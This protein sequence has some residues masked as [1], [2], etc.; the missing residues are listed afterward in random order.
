VLQPRTLSK[1]HF[2]PVPKVREDGH[3]E[4]LDRGC[5]RNRNEGN[6]EA[7]RCKAGSGSGSTYPAIT[8]FPIGCPTHDKTANNV[9]GSGREK[10]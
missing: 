5:R 1:R 8:T 9:G 2:V 4:E 3:E 10:C 6:A 7:S